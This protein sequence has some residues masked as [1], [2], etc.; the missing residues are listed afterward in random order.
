MQKCETLASDNVAHQL[1]APCST[2]VRVW[3]LHDAF[4]SSIWVQI[5][6]HELHLH[7]TPQPYH[8]PARLMSCP[9]RV[10]MKACGPKSI[11]IG[12]HFIPS[13]CNPKVHASLRQA[14]SLQP[15]AQP[16]HQPEVRALGG[17]RHFKL[18]WHHTCA[19]MRITWIVAL[20]SKS[21]PAHDIHPLIRAKYL[22]SNV[23]CRCHLTWEAQCPA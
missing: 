9:C 10:R 15:P 12:R 18:G 7:K 22:G 16:Q 23:C 2:I 17:V 5:S 3:H 14:N 6:A 11:N 21:M 19:E 8:S 1:K 20:F 13:V 4:E